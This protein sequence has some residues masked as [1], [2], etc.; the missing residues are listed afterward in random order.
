M[1]TRS[2]I[3]LEKEDG[4]VEFIYCHWD[5]YLE[6]NGAIL[7][8]YYNDREKVEKLLSCGDI[9]A[10]YPDVEKS[11][12]TA[13]DKN[14]AGTV[15]SSKEFWLSTLKS[16]YGIEYVYVFTK[17]NKW[18]VAYNEKDWFVTLLPFV[19]KHFDKAE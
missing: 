2:N 17:D 13:Y 9:S 15:L 1:A 10:L 6:H 3:G 12:E 18:K 5:G 19:E 4:S 14:D 7:Q 8:Q 16:D 11:L